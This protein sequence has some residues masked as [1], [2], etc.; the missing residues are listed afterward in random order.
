MLHRS[1]S[2]AERALQPWRWLPLTI[3]FRL[4]RVRALIGRRRLL[5]RTIV[6]AGVSIAFIVWLSMLS[7][8][9]D[10]RNRWTNAATVVVLV[11]ERSAGDAVSVEHVELVE[12]PIG[13]IPSDAITNTETLAA[14]A[15]GPLYPGDVLRRRDIREPGA[16]TVPAGQRAIAVP[17]NN[18]VLAL[19]AGDQ[20]ELIVFA[21]TVGFPGSDTAQVVAGQILRRDEGSVVVAIPD[22]NAALVA[23]GIVT[24]QVVLAAA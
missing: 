1:G 2:V 6:I 8:I 15:S 13:A 11:D 21:D 23:A 17:L 19:K 10:E 7:T 20:V 24:G 9:Q 12:L 5:R 18:D 14:V 3:R 22:T 4:A 16:G